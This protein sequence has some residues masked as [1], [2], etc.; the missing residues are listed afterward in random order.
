MNGRNHIQTLCLVLLVLLT[1]IGQ[2]AVA[3]DA[4][5]LMA[6][7]I[8]HFEKGGVELEV[9]L[10]DM[11]E[12]GIDGTAVVKMDRERFTLKADGNIIW[13]DGKTQWTLRA[14]DGTGGG[15]ELYI[16][17]P[18]EEDL[19]A[20][21]PYI[22]MKNYRQQYTASTASAVTMP[23]GATTCVRL[24]NRDSRADIQ[25]A[26]VYLDGECRLVAV[27]ATVQGTTVSLKVRSFRTGV[28][29]KDADFVCR[30]KDYDA[31]VIDLR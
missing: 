15:S 1:G 19:Q 29:F 22:L 3:A 2:R 13:F 17:E 31:E 28:K 16:G 4:D 14:D 8:A 18:T 6:K 20:V 24:Q 12:L 27:T 7:A 26:L 11:A 5:D 30:V 23:H 10:D 9:A 25:D 21:N